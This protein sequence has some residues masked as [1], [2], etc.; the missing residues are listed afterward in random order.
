L[1][2]YIDPIPGQVQQWV[3]LG[4]GGNQDEVGATQYHYA[5]SEPTSAHAFLGYVNR[6]KL[7]VLR[8][9]NDP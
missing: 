8:N 5:T 4:T 1:L 7:M 9:P 2:G 3:Q 6:N